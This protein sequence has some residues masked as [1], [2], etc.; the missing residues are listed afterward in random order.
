MNEITQSGPEFPQG[1]LWVFGYGSLMWRPG[2]EFIEQVPARLIGEHRALC[3]YSFDH[4]GTPEKPGLVLGL[5]RGGA[6]RGVAFRVASKLRGKTVEYLLSR[7][8]TTNVYREVLRSVWLGNEPRQRVSALT[9][10]VDRGHVQYAG[11]LSPA[12]QL[13]HVLQGHGQSG[14]NRD[15]VLATV[16][17]IEAEG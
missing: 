7:E 16:K 17:A 9:Y 4:R 5:D 13:R 8:Q 12:E 14:V 1:E 2:F 15:Y 3:V 11:R 10:V 6:C